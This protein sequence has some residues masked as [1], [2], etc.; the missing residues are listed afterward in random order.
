LI[1]MKRAH[2]YEQTSALIKLRTTSEVYILIVFVVA[3]GITSAFVL[4]YSFNTRMDTA[5]SSLEGY[6]GSTLYTDK[7]LYRTSEA[8]S[9]SI[10]LANT[11]EEDIILERVQY[12]LSVYALNNDASPRAFTTTDTV[13]FEGV[14]VNPHSYYIFTLDE[15]WDQ[16]DAQGRQVPDGKYLIEIQIPSYNLTLSK[17]IYIK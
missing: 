1:K 5:G 10:K 15:T 4:N 17:I 11:W 8:I 16:K 6:F 12:Q 14:A 9:S 7:D 2:E 3:L 13:E